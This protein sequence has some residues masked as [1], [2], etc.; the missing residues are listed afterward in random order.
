MALVPT[1]FNYKGTQV[2]IDQPPPKRIK[3]GDGT[4]KINVL[5]PDSP[6]FSLPVEMFTKGILSYFKA[7]DLLNFERVCSQFYVLSGD[8]PMW[9]ELFSRTC[10]PKKDSISFRNQF[11]SEFDRRNPH[12]KAAMSG[13]EF[14]L[15]GKYIEIDPDR[16]IECYNQVIMNS[17]IPQK[18]KIEAIF[19]K[20]KMVGR[21]FVEYPF[22]DD[23]GEISSINLQL[24]GLCLSDLS[25]RQ[26]A[27]A[28]LYMSIIIAK[29]FLEETDQDMPC[30]ETW[31]GI[32]DK[33]RGV[34]ANEDA[35]PEDRARATLYLGI[36]KESNPSNG[37][38]AFSYF[39]PVRTNL[40]AFPEDRAEAMYYIAR[41]KV[42][43][44][45][46]NITDSEA[47]QY[48]ENVARDLQ[49]NL[50]IRLDAAYSQALMISKDR[51]PS[52]MRMEDAYRILDSLSN[53][54]GWRKS[55]YKD[56]IEKANL[57]KVELRV[58]KNIDLMTDREA[59]TI[60]KDMLEGSSPYRSHAKSL[61]QRLADKIQAQ[62]SFIDVFD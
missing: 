50:R 24:N 11:L 39:E 8:A 4:R 14:F 30:D 52:G 54:V 56:I 23:C 59:I 53:L 19:D 38:A 7:K 28:T 62:S 6:I 47:F 25:E 5:G 31:E 44:K 42:T 16:A 26:V 21:D 45:I 60:L 57:L 10:L 15:N 1:Q 3:T 43:R 9:K 22:K 58:N 36:T 40:Q 2:N 51:G 61:M 27:R 35:A 46:D 34:A 17:R 32:Y 20:A 41:L 13:A 37:A 55:A 49:A 33:L 48:L 18:E 29:S 12:P